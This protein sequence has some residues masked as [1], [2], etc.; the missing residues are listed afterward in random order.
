[1]SRGDYPL[2]GITA[3]RTAAKDDREPA[4]ENG[5]ERARDTRRSVVGRQ[6][7]FKRVEAGP[8]L[9]E[10]G[11]GGVA[12]PSLAV[13]DHH[14][15]NRL[16][17]LS[18][19]R[20]DVMVATR[21]VPPGNPVAHAEHAERGH[22]RVDRFEIARRYTILDHAGQLR[23][24]TPASLAMLRTQRL[25]QQW[26]GLVEDTEL[27]RRLG[28]LPDH[29]LGEVPQFALRRE[30]RTSSQGRDVVRQSTAQVLDQHSQQ[31]FL[32][33]HIVIQGRPRHAH[34]VR[35]VLQRRGLVTT[36][37]EQLGGFVQQFASDQRLAGSTAT[38]VARRFLLHRILPRAQ[39]L[40]PCH[41]HIVT[42]RTR[43]PHLTVYLCVDNLTYMTTFDDDM[44]HIEQ[45]AHTPYPD[46][47]R[48]GYRR[49][50]LWSGRT[51]SQELRDA[52]TAH[53]DRLALVTKDVR[54]TYAELDQYCAEFGTG[55]LASTSLRPGDAVMFSMGNVAETVVAY[56]G[57]LHAGLVPVCT[58]PQHR[59]REIG[60]L[61]QHVG[62]R[63]HFVQA[64]YRGYALTDLARAVATSTPS[65]TELVVARGT[66]PPEGHSFAD[67]L[68]N[69]RRSKAVDVQVDVDG[70][71]V[72]Q[73]SGG[74]TGL[75]KVAPRLHEEYV[76][77]SRQWAQTLGWQPGTTV[78]YPL[79]VMHNAGIALALQ[80]A[81]LTGATIVL[82]DSAD[83]GAIL[84]AIEAERPNVLPLVPP[85]VAI[86][87]LDDP[88]SRQTD[89]SC[90]KDF[91]VGGQR[92]AV[93]TARRLDDELGIRCRQMFG[94]AEGMFLVT[95]PDAPDEVR[96]HTVGAPISPEDEIRIYD[97]GTETEVPD[98]TEGELCAR[99]PYTIRGYYRAPEH[100]RQTFTS[101]GFY[102]T[103]DLARR[104]RSNGRAYY[105]IDGRIKDVINRGVEK[106]HAE[107]VEE[108]M[109][110]HPDIAQAAL[111]A[112]PD[113][114]L[115][116]RACAYLVPTPG[117]SGLSV[118][119]LA[120][121]LLAHGLAKYK[122]PE[123][124]EIVD[125][126]P[127]TNV[128]KVSKKLLRAD[129]AAKLQQQ[130]ASPERNS[131]CDVSK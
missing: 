122:L 123:R 1:M 71:A 40:S 23:Q 52:A 121:H 41:Q 2:F 106:I 110:R 128:G 25:W 127:L 32:A 21:P 26:L 5:R 7:P 22:L 90:V 80:P 72:C 30:I 79:P 93:E 126:F 57:A 50:G 55:L 34:R 112:M 67:V 3:C 36:R 10:R 6:E 27:L 20:F 38:T 124:V 11:P 81:H 111:V 95:P 60:L 19:Y 94:M 48:A 58:L 84:D 99:G 108:L 73:L 70:I 31:I 45:A 54:W 59:E 56:Y 78:L 86:R 76:Y 18:R 120:E 68:E 9:G 91:I 28:A 49:L 53:A 47:V 118:Q 43:W 61:A 4:R 103:G 13:V 98:G 83:T 37:R 105:S 17:D 116:E 107:E 65:L 66:T 16:S 42:S 101:D 125:R 74:T 119:Q 69:G 97:I 96:L 46:D 14:V 114:V 75:P 87:L 62:A 85:A 129:I 109:L 115:G 113:P 92:L 63:G 35:Y 117:T 77:N 33:G 100:N 24:H 8:G 131:A 130:L 51:I 29:E 15:H 102:R 88:R 89:L 44:A 39:R 82:V 104:H 12:V 64:D